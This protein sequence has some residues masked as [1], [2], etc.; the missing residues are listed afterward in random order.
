MIIF[1]IF[2]VGI[3]TKN[4]IFYIIL[5]LFYGSAFYSNGVLIFWLRR[6]AR[7]A[8]DANLNANNQVRINI[9]IPHYCIINDMTV[10]KNEECAICKELLNENIV[11]TTCNHV[12]H[13]KCLLQSTSHNNLTC[14]LCRNNLYEN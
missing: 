1:I 5:V 11:V 12:F 3:T 8:N 7:L 10:Y 2:I 9:E 13:E 6:Y 14:P 4:I